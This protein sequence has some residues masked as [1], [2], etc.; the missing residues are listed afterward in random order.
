MKVGD[1][2]QIKREDAED[3]QYDWAQRRQRSATYPGVGVI[4][5]IHGGTRVEP[6][7]VL[8]PSGSVSRH[9]R[10]WLETVEGA[11][12]SRTTDNRAPHQEP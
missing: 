6:I 3:S 4:V 7:E 1:L 11:P 10:Y 2:V 9:D 12:P 5:D 8:W